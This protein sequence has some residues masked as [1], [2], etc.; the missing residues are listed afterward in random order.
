MQEYIKKIL[1][2]EKTTL[3]IS[4][5]EMEDIMKIVKPLEGSGL[6]L[7]GVSETIQNEV[8]EPKRGFPSTLLGTLDANL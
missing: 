1:G 7:T 4:S 3:I 6:L 2:S 5:D 8:K